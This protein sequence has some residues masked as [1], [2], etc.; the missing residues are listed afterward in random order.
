MY[1]TWLGTAGFILESQGCRILLDPFLS[2]PPYARPETPSF[3]KNLDG[4]QGI[5]LTH[6]HFDH[7]MDAS[8][9]RERSGC[10]VY[11]TRDVLDLVKAAGTDSEFLHPVTWHEEFPI[12]PFK[13]KPIPSRHIVFDKLLIASTL[14]RCR[15]QLASITALAMRWPKKSVT[16]WQITMEEKTILHFGSAGWVESE[17]AGLKPDLLLVPVQG[18]TDIATV[19]AQLTACVNPRR[20]VAHHW[21]DFYPP[22]SQMIDLSEYQKI[23]GQLLPDTGIIIP[24]MGRKMD[25]FV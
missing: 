23:L 25:P 3:V 14:K 9:L 12:G 16:A 6:G 8:W 22:L 24:E 13:I 20:V 7:A 1:L 5:L 21:D 2:R 17:V 4:V 18:R 19:A 15:K 10:G 11:G